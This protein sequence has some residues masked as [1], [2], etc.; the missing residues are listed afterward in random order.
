MPKSIGRAVTL[1]GRQ[2][3]G[4]NESENRLL[5]RPMLT[6]DDQERSHLRQDLLG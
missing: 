2:V 3:E 5:I 6:A 1:G 4:K